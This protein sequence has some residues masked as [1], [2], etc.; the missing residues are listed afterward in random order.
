MA[1]PD[2]RLS[3]EEIARHPWVVKDVGR[4]VNFEGEVLFFFDFISL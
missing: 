2:D 1:N 4:P 3:L